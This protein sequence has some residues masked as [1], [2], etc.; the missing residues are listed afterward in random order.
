[1]YLPERGVRGTA[2]NLVK[3]SAALFGSFLGTEKNAP[4]SV[5]NKVDIVYKIVFAFAAVI[6]Y[7]R[8]RV[9]RVMR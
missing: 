3:P 1:M 2:N 6:V 7:N 4:S 9:Y 5:P 8:T